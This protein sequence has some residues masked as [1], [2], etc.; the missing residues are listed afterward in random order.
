MA[1]VVQPEQRALRV[2]RSV[3][4][5]LSDGAVTDTCIIRTLPTVSNAMVACRVLLYGVQGDCTGTALSPA[6]ADDVTGITQGLELV[7]KTADPGTVCVL[8]QLSGAVDAGSC[9]NE[10]TAGWCYIPGACA[11]LSTDPCPQSI[12]TTSGLAATQIG[13]S[14]SFLACP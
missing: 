11:S 14:G 12:C 4:A 6:T 8:S 3:Y 7:G 9:T 2:S 1:A 10:S 13:Y 5:E